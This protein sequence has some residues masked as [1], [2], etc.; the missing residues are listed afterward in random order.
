MFLRKQDF[1]SKPEGK[2]GLAWGSLTAPSVAPSGDPRATAPAGASVGTSSA[3]SPQRRRASNARRRMVYECR[4]LRQQ[5]SA[6][7]P[8]S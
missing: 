5:V 3:S 7:R 8:A 6:L 4:S 2:G 1:C